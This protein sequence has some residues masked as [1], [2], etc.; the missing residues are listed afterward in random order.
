MTSSISSNPDCGLWYRRV[1]EIRAA[2]RPRE[3]QQQGGRAGKRRRVTRRPGDSDD[4]EVDEQEDAISEFRRVQIVQET[5]DHQ[6]AAEPR[7]LPELKPLNDELA[8]DRRTHW[9]LVLGDAERPSPTAARLLRCSC[10]CRH[11]V[12]YRRSLVKAR[13]VEEGKRG[14]SSTYLMLTVRVRASAAARAA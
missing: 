6:G 9:A 3:E 13:V 12:S 2:K 1:T 11:R 14:Y 4:D 7:P 8:A 10:R 5:R